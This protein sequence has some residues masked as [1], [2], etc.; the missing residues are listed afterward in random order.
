M[1]RS[2][3]A[4]L[5]V[6]LA[7]GLAHGHFPFIVPDADGKRVKIIFSDSL[8]PDTK[9]NIEKIANTKLTLRDAAGNESPL[10]W[11]KGEGCYI[12]E[13][14]AGGGSRVVYG[15]TDYGVLQKGE[16]KPFRLL[17]HA[18]AILGPVNSTSLGDKPLVEVVPSGEPGKISFQVLASGK[19]AAASEV[20][21]LLPGGGKKAVKT[22]AEGRTPPFEQ[23]GR[24]GVYAN[25]F[26]PKSGEHAGQ[27][28]EQV[29]HYATLVVDVGAKK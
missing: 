1:A 9:V 21:V 12:V 4:A 23:L 10:K 29:R 14:S 25:W 18:K 13:V 19:P 20:T 17:Y 15:S 28:Y 11:T 24:Y 16:S 5:F 26:E 8:E 27:K 2:L 3:L 7:V 6:V 22:D